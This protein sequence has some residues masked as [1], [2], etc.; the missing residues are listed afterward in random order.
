MRGQLCMKGKG[1]TARILLKCCC[2]FTAAAAGAVQALQLCPCCANQ[3]TEQPQASAL[4]FGGT[5]RGSTQG[6][7]LCKLLQRQGTLYLLLS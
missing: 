4:S 6:M 7:V 1:V 3:A 2:M 5:G